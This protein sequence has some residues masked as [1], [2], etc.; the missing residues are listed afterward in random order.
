M[1]EP[2]TG[3]ITSWQANI[4]SLSSQCWQLGNALGGA[5]TWVGAQNWAYAKIYLEAASGF[6]HEMAHILKFEGDDVY[7]NMYDTLHYIDENIGGGVE[8]DMEAILAAIWNGDVL[9]WFL[10]INFI[11]SMRA[12]IWNIEIYDTHLADWYRHFST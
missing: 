2:L 9:R 5:A 1:P 8:L 3:Y 6:A 7:D 12:G 4:S 10:F 11:D